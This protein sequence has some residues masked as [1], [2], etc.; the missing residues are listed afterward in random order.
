MLIKDC[1]KNERNISPR[2]NGIYS[3]NVDTKKSPIIDRYFK[4][5]LSEKKKPNEKKI[6]II[7]NSTVIK[8]DEFKSVKIGKARK[9]IEI[10][11]AVFF[12]IFNA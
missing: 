9:I 5:I 4:K 2:I 6:K 8:I 1:C 11:H 3:G 10:K 7:F 12:S